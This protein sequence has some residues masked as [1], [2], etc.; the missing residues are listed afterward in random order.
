MP[1][2]MDDKKR[3]VNI[4]ISKEVKIKM[5][6]VKHTGQSYDGFIQE[7]LAHWK[8]RQKAQELMR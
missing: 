1:E 4:N 2:E 6:E 5:D 7:M 8:S 3:R